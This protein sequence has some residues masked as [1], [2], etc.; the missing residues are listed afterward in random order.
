[1]HHYFFC[2]VLLLKCNAPH[3]QWIFATH[4]FGI[5]RLGMVLFFPYPDIRFPLPRVTLASFLV[6]YLEKFPSRNINDRKK[7]RAVILTVPYA[8]VRLNQ[9]RNSAVEPIYEKSKQ[10]NN[11]IIWLNYIQASKPYFTKQTCARK[12]FFDTGEIT[13]FYADKNRNDKLE[14]LY[15]CVHMNICWKW[16]RREGSGKSLDPLTLYAQKFVENICIM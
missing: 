13:D 15:V 1:M 14:F 9:F 2:W 11:Q 10:K 7:E 16:W 5:N 4:L 8:S 12:T 6:M 3:R